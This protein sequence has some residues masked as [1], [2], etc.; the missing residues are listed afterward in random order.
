M[1]EGRPTIRVCFLACWGLQP[2]LLHLLANACRRV[3]CRAGEWGGDLGGVVV[4][5]CGTCIR[6]KC[7]MG[8]LH[9]VKIS[10]RLFSHSVTL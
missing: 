10:P 2:N 7:Q 6:P 8:S 5:W 9:F 4:I 3:I 1:M